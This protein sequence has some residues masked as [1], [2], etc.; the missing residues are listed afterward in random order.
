MCPTCN[1]I[2]LLEKVGRECVLNRRFRA[3]HFERKQNQFS[4]KVDSVAKLFCDLSPIGL[5]FYSK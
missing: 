5:N 3:V 1:W 2:F 4:G